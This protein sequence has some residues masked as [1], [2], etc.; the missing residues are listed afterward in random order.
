MVAAQRDAGPAGSGCSWLVQASF[1]LSEHILNRHGSSC[2]SQP[3]GVT[4]GQLGSKAASSFCHGQEKDRK[5]KSRT[6]LSLP[7]ALLSST[8]SPKGREQSKSS[9]LLFVLT[10]LFFLLLINNKKVFLRIFFSLL[11]D[12]RHTATCVF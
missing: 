1:L 7:P 9:L 5:R 3:K 11:T 8:E 12:H 6:K 2:L 10:L 4:S